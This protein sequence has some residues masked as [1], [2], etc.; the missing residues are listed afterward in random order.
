MFWKDVGIKITETMAHHFHVDFDAIALYL[1]EKTFPCEVAGDKEKKANFRKDCKAFSIVNGQL[2]YKD[3]RLV[4]SS[5]EAQQTIIHDIHVGLGEDSKAK[6]MAGHRG[7]DS[8]HQKIVNRFFWHNI[9][10]DVEEYIKKCD[11]CQKHGKIKKS[12]H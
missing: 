10:S 7:R 8:T 12:I 11:Q 9:K 2:M 4:I 6:A 3:S 5:K 1:R